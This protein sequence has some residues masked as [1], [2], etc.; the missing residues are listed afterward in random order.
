[1]KN[2]N[3]TKRGLLKLGDLEQKLELTYPCDW[4]YK[5]IGEERKKLEQAIRDVLLEREH[6]LEHSN[7]SK[8]GK[9]VSLNLDLLVQNE[10][11][12]QFIYEALKAHQHVKMVL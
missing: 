3:D 6:R 4:R 9:Y 2:T 11:E 12:R 1:M 8:S 5:V 7:A 10:D